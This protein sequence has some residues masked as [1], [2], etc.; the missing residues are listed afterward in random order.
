MLPDEEKFRA[1]TFRIAGFALLTPLGRLFLDPVGLFEIYG[2]VGL[3]FYLLMAIVVGFFGL[4]LIL[5]CFDII[6][7]N[8]QKS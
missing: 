7:T 4:V 1:E 5:K 3:I 8:K 2:I 6:Y